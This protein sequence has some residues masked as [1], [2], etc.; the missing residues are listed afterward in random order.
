MKRNIVVCCDGTGNEYSEK[1]TSV[2]RLVEIIEKSKPEQ[3]VYYDPGVGTLAAPGAITATRRA[4]SR[5]SGLAFGIGLGQNIGDAYEYLMNN[6]QE[7]DRVF[8]FGF[9]RGAFTVRAL[10]GML[11]YCGLLK[12]GNKNLIPYTLRMYRRAK[13]LIDQEKADIVD[14]FKDAFSR[15]CKPHFIGVWDTIK[16]VTGWTF[17]DRELRSVTIGRHAIAID[18]KRGDYFPVLWEPSESGD[19]DIKA[20][21]KQVWFAGCHADV[22]G[23]HEENGLRD[24]ALKWMLDEARG[25]YLDVDTSANGYSELVASQQNGHKDD[26]HESYRWGWWLRPRRIRKISEGSW[27]HQSVYDKIDDCPDYRPRNLPSKELVKVEP[28][29]R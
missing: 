18:E 28:W 11:H 6:F 17:P 10:A 29:K 13:R 12:K 4:M 16:S 7:D 2:V 19:P 21:V 27:V 3:L 1:K 9:S 23:A 24:I 20:D 5:G 8:L 25:Q 15:P 26:I 14:G 22:G